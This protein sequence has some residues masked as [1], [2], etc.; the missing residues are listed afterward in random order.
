MSIDCFFWAQGSSD[1]VAL[2]WNFL[3]PSTTQGLIV[4][5]SAILVGLVVVGVILWRY[6]RTGDST[7]KHRH[8]R[9][10][11]REQ[12]EEKPPENSNLDAEEDEVTDPKRRRRR[13]R[14]H[15]PRNPTLS[16]TGGLPPVR[17]HSPPGP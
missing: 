13:R 12:Q 6:G 14:G 4:I 16:E 7:T 11:H 8:H 10:H 5:G 15:R 17:T 2:K 9:H 3:D 1:E